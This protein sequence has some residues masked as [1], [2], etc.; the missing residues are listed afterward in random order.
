MI[1]AK[2]FRTQ[3]TKIFTT[4]EGILRSQSGSPA[5]KVAQICHKNVKPAKNTALSTLV[6]DPTAVILAIN[7]ILY[8]HLMIITKFLGPKNLPLDHKVVL[9]PQ[10]RPKFTKKTTEM[11]ILSLHNHGQ[12]W[13]HVGI[14][15]VVMLITL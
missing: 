11:A 15:Y 12:I 10:K 14:T 7:Y 13:A 2:G 9:R 4:H 3:S 8:F 5:I 6:R 1:L